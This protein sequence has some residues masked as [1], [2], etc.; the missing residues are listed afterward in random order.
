MSREKGKNKGQNTA[1]SNQKNIERIKP[2]TPPHKLTQS[3]HNCNDASFHFGD[4]DN[5]YN[6]L[7]LI[8]I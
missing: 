1:Q 8:R 5:N 2:V 4:N 3:E 7:T 6:E